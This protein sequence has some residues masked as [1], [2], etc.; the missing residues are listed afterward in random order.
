[1]SLGPGLMERARRLPSGGMLCGN[2]MGCNEH[3]NELE[4][5]G[6]YNQDQIPKH[7]TETDMH[8]SFSHS[9]DHGSKCFAKSSDL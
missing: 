8:L 2:R 7:L 9:I 5:E 4:L 3:G 6:Q 1:M